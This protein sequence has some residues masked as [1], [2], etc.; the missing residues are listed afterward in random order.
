LINIHCRVQLY[1]PFIRLYPYQYYRE[2]ERGANEFDSEC[3]GDA[4]DMY[5][6]RPHCA[7]LD[8]K[9]GESGLS[10]TNVA[11]IMN[12]VENTLAFVG[13]LFRLHFDG[14]FVQ[15]PAIAQDRSRKIC[16][17]RLPAAQR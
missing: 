5:D 12:N 4:L 2:L 9:S 14:L 3:S 16:H 11:S 17:W 15:L 10:T 8:L 6:G 13:I 7:Q 1:S